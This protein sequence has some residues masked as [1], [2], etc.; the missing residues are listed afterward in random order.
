MARYDIITK[1]NKIFISANILWENLNKYNLKRAIV[2]SIL[3]ITCP[4]SCVITSTLQ[5]FKIFLTA[6]YNT[7]AHYKLY[8]QDYVRLYVDTL[9]P[10]VLTEDPSRPFITS[11]P[12]NGVKSEEQGWVSPNPY[13]T[14][15]GDCK[16]TLYY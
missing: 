15:Y 14:H 5:I 2:K 3:C 10:I 4:G 12:T 16:C 13:D 8:Y 7:S 1:V 9:R 6:R 11:S